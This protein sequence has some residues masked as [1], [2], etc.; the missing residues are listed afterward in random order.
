MELGV[1]ARGWGSAVGWA[2]CA[3]AVDVNGVGWVGG[4]DVLLV[5]DMEMEWEA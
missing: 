3:D 5:M 4:R 1:E 2:E